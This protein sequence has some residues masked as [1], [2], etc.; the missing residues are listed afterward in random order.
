MATIVEG[1]PKAPFSIAST[2]MCKGG[3]NPLHEL[4]CT[5]VLIL[6]VIV[7]MFS[8]FYSLVFRQINYEK[9]TGT[10]YFCNIILIRILLCIS[11]NWIK[12]EIHRK[13]I[14]EYYSQSKATCPRKSVYNNWLSDQRI[15][16]KQKHVVDENRTQHFILNKKNQFV[17]LANG[18]MNSVRQWPG[19]PGFNPRLNH[20]KD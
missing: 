20:T 13:L 19:R 15:L 2:P 12:F 7:T 8:S 4:N 5:S 18:L 1:D 14:C 9:L 3:C 10:R 16:I 11:V 6:I 17:S